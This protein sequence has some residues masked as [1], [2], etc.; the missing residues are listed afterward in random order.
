MSHSDDELDDLIDASDKSQEGLTT[1]EAWL[2][3]SAG[4]YKIQLQE[5]VHGR[6]LPSAAHDR[7][8]PE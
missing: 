1:H 5:D 7:R 3:P 4:G 8:P 2:T 6:T